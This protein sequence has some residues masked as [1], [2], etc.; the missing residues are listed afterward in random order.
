M[1][2]KG[3]NTCN[4]ALDIGDSD[5]WILSPQLSTMGIRSIYNPLLFPPTDGLVSYYHLS[6]RP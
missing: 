4:T 3:F 1:H 6:T 5:S 2:W